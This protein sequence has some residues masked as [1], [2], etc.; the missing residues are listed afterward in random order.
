MDFTADKKKKKKKDK[1]K[2]SKF[3]DVADQGEE[4]KQEK[5][6]KVEIPSSRINL[7]KVEGYEAYEYEFMLNRI[8][9]TIGD[10]GAQQG[11][12]KLIEPICTRTKTKSTWV[13]FDSQAVALNRSHQ[14]IIDYFMSELGCGGNLGSNNEMVL[15]GGFQAKNFLKMIRKYIEDYVRCKDCKG[16]QTVMVKEDRLT[17]LKCEKC[18]ASRNVQGIAGR[19]VATRRGERRKAKQAIA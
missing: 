12:F 6:A 7:N 15:V 14:H 19:F 3:D 2:A 17:Y 1:E 11:S 5:K 13:N 9:E 10:D 18:R 16:L 4:V 8:I